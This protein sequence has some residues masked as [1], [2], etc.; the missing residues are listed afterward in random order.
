M[1]LINK[2]V[3]TEI[4]DFLS[5]KDCLR[6]L[7]DLKKISDSTKGHIDLGCI[8]AGAKLVCCPEFYGYLSDIPNAVKGEK[9]PENGYPAD[10]LYNAVQVGEYLIGLKNAL[11]K[12]V[13][14]AAEELKIIGTKQGYAKCNV[15]CVSDRA[16]ITEDESIKKAAEKAGISVLLIK[17]GYVFLDGYE[18]GFI[19][20]ASVLTNKELIFTGDIS[21]HPDFGKIIS[22][23]SERGVKTDFI[24]NFPLTDVGSPVFI[25]NI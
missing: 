13:T 25:Q 12:K 20:G 2:N 4:I 22:F 18:H 3:P 21:K 11:D 6:L 14:E 10:V 16:I 9:D 8:K 7:P 23:C 1:I 19:G 24:D 17:K 15:V 5:K